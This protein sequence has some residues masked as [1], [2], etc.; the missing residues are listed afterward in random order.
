[1]NLLSTLTVQK[2]QKHKEGHTFAGWEGYTE[3]MTMNGEDITFTAQ[4]TVN[5]YTVTWIIDGTTNVET[6]AYGAA[7]VAPTVPEKEGYRTVA[8]LN[9]AGKL[10]NVPEKMPATNLVYMALYEAN[11]YEIEYYVDGKLAATVSVEYD[12]TIKPITV[13]AP[14][15]FAFDRW[16]TD[17][18]MTTELA[19]D[20]TVTGNAKIYGKFVST[21]YN[22]TFIVS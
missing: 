4:W 20:A 3:G 15:G 7:I 17:A 6:Y 1:M 5:N 22:A 12:E 9:E 19:A 16:Y 13:N 18:E 14:V 2:Q 21:K 8:W 10:V 11:L